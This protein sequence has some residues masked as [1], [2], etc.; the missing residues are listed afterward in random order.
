MADMFFE[1]ITPERVVITSEVKSVVLPGAEGEMTVMPGHETLVTVLQL[2]MVV[3][4]DFEGRTSRAF[5]WGGFAEIT[6]RKV[7]VLV[8]RTLSPDDL[9]R[10]ALDKEIGEMETIIETSGSETARR[11]A[12]FAR[13]RLLQLR[14]TVAY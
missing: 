9:S 7:T 14:A 12:E 4:T 8:E 2:G 3:L 5:I 1:L 10:D 13:D 11:E 6:G